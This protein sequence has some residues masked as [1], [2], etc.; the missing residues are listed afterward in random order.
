[1][2]I[3]IIQDDA[4]VYVPIDIVSAKLG[5][6][7]IAIN[8]LIDTGADITT[9]SPL[10]AINNQI[11]FSKLEKKKGITIG[12]GGAQSCEYEIR[13]V[14]FRFRGVDGN[15]I[16]AKLDRIDVIDPGPEEKRNSHAFMIPSLLGTDMLQKLKFTYNSH[17]KLEL[18][19]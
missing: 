4:R 12:I 8:F 2:E 6:K 1:M 10:D 19:K 5:N 16:Y 13:D 14:G 3:K 9:I 7:I 11:D 15:P 18:K 17:A